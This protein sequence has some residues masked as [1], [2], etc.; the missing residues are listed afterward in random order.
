M[1]SFIKIMGPPLLE[2]VREL[3][4][5]A[6]DMPQVCVMDEA[7]LLD[8]PRRM[9]R[10][11]GEPIEYPEYVSEFFTRRTGV[12]VRTERCSNIISESGEL[13]GEY[14]FFFEWFEEPSMEQ[15]NDLIGRI[16]E[17]LGPLGCLY[18]ITTSR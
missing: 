1:R 16:D 5:I 7:I 9:A 12:R 3:E 2:A 15:I 17:A 14:D 6:V 10:D 11:I 18:S 4:K 8:I 13:L